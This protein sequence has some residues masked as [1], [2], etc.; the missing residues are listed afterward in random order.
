[1]LPMSAVQWIWC[2]DLQH[3]NRQCS[4]KFFISATAVNKDKDESFQHN[5]PKDIADTD[6]KGNFFLTTSPYC[7][8]NGPLAL[9]RRRGAA[10]S[11][12]PPP[13]SPSIPLS[14][15]LLNIILSP[16]KSRSATTICFHDR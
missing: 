10:L 14:H 13:L 4:F 16:P 7:R 3:S 11:F 12:P 1:M 5:D 2:P 8:R 9:P 6:E 15:R